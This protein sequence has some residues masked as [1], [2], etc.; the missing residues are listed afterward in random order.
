MY[1]SVSVIRHDLLCSVRHGIR[2]QVRFSVL[3]T[4]RYT[5]RYTAIRYSV[6]YG[7][8]STVRYTARYTSIRYCLRYGSHST[9]RYTAR[10]PVVR[11]SLQ[12]YD[13]RPGIR[14][15]GTSIVYGTV[16]SCTVDDAVSGTFFILVQI[17]AEYRCNVQYTEPTV[18][19]TTQSTAV[20]LP[21]IPVV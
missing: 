4:V 2:Y 1:A 19:Q 3:S 8:H 18:F 20:A 14:Y 12:L 15:F 17:G 5:A 7:S 10:Y 21:S 13:R 16:Y 9:V 6:R 11:Y